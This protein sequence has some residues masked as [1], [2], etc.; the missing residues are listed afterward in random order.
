[1]LYMRLCYF[2]NERL[3]ML[4]QAHGLLLPLQMFYNFYCGIIGEA[5]V[6]G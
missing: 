6:P 1:M 5:A 3:C 2:Q 4:S